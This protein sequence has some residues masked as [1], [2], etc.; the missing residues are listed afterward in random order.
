MGFRG[1]GLPALEAAFE[2]HEVAMIITHPEEIESFNVAFAESVQ[3]FGACHGISTFVSKSARE[4]SIREAVGASRP[5]IILSSN[6]RRRIASDLLRM[7]RFGGINVH[8]S[9]LPQYAGFAPVN[10]AVAM[11]ERITGV[12]IHT[13]VD[14]I[15]A[16]AIIA[17]ESVEIADD[18]TATTVFHKMTPVV[19]RLVKS[20]LNQIESGTAAPRPQDTG[21]IE[22]FP[23]RTEYDLRIN[24]HQ[25]CTRILNLIR[26]QSA[27]FP[28]AFTS[29]NGKRVD[30]VGAVP[31]DR[32]YRGTPG[33]IVE[34]GPSGIVVLCGED[35]ESR[36]QGLLIT[37][38][39]V[40]GSAPTQ[41]RQII[42]STTENFG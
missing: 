17:Q 36:Q 15:D 30:I 42:K 27:P 18:D 20:A 2:D 12:T 29:W 4:E 34:V 25:T 40:D 9:L 28:P 11:G 14:G 3:E 38:I 16:G 21:R 13:M 33:R 5:D 41:P 39:S 7:A 32:F 31:V 22:Y 35:H 37:S 23:K 6:W 1:W 8:R 24:W 10:W 19:R 26:A